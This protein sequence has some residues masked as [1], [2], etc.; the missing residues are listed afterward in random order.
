VKRLLS[1]LSALITSLDGWQPLREGVDIKRLVGDPDAGPSIALLRYQAGAHVP[2]H[3]HR[4]FE[5]IYVVSGEQ[6]D[7]RGTYPAGSLVTNH[8]GDE[9]SVRSEHGCV[10]LIV[11][12]KPVEF[13]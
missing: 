3:V 12:E 13:R 1:S 2:A 6:S 4:G 8:D 10:V 7:E 11:W 9:H 5:L